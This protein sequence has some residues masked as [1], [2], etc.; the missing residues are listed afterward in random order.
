MEKIEAS[1]LDGTKPTVEMINRYIV[2]IDGIVYIRKSTVDE[3]IKARDDFNKATI[4]KS[5]L[6]RQI[7]NNENILLSRK[8]EIE[9]YETITGD[10][11]AVNSEIAVQHTVLHA[12]QT[13]ICSG[14]PVEVGREM[15]D[16]IGQIGIKGVTPLFK[17]LKKYEAH[18]MTEQEILDTL[19]SLTNQETH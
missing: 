15:L 1:M 9:K 12:I 2:K 11:L 19:R 7:Q 6:E 5:S 3:Y 13:C 10:I 14:L 4:K 8:N 16:M 17:C 18:E